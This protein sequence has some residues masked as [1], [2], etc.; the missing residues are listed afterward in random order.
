MKPALYYAIR[1]NL[2]STVVA[3][4]SEKGTRRWHGRDC[5]YNEATHGTFDQLRGKFAS[6]EEA[7]ACRAGVLEIDKRFDVLIEVHRNATTKLYRECRDE[8]DA[9]IKEKSDGR[10]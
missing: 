9:F 7:E 4:T 6:Q 3:V 1:R 8:I 5:Q 2:Y 10:A